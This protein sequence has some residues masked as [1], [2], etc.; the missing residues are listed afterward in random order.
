MAFAQSPE[1]QR[2]WTDTLA[3]VRAEEAQ[4]KPWLAQAR[5]TPLFNQALDQLD[6]LGPQLG[7]PWTQEQREQL[8]GAIALEA[9]AV[10]LSSIDALA[11][12]RD[13]MGLTAVSN[14]PTDQLL[15]RR[16]TVDPTQ[17]AEQP[18]Q[19]SM[20]QFNEE[21]QRQA[22]QAIEAQQRQEQSRGMS[23]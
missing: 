14:N 12:T 6:K 16:A 9:K 11:P 18:L 17:A 3:E 5:E 1:G 23:M 4:Q 20:Q 22:N 21:T 15:G 7:Q 10:R 8:A 2:I 19:Q 13:G